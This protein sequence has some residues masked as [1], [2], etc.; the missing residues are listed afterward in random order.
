MHLAAYCGY[1]EIV[2]ILIKVG[3]NLNAVNVCKETSLNRAAKYNNTKYL[4]F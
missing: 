2:D 1:I 3:V 4:I